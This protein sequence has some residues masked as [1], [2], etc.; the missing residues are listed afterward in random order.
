MSDG[1]L[2]SRINEAV[3]ENLY[4]KRTVERTEQIIHQRDKALLRIT[5]VIKGLNREDQQ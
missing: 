3:S 1:D 5:E 2:Y 4:L